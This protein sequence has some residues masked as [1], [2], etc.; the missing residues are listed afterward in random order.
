MI[1]FVK[2]FEHRIQGNYDFVKASQLSL[3]TSLKSHFNI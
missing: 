1:N 3:L 2:Q